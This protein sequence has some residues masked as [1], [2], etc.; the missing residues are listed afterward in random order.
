MCKKLKHA[1]N[2]LSIINFEE[3]LTLCII[4]LFDTNKQLIYINMYISF[5][6]YI[7]KSNTQ[8]PNYKSV[9]FIMTSP[10]AK[11]DFNKIKDM[12]MINFK[13]PDQFFTNKNFSNQDQSDIDEET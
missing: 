13:H 2:M 7:Q 10:V 6:L 4:T 12:N 9:I 1:E 11:S 8:F 5:R 3:Y